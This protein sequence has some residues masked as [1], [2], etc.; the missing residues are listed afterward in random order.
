VIIIIFIGVGICYV[1][2]GY[3]GLDVVIVD[4]LN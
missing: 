1:G 4:Q 3:G 2:H